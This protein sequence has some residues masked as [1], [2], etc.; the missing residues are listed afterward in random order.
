MAR[1]FETILYQ[2][3]EGPEGGYAVI[4]LNRPDKLNAFNEQLHADLRAALDLVEGDAGVRALVFTG[5]G[6]G[7]CAGQDLGDR[8]LKPG[9]PPRDTGAGLEAN[10]NPLVLRIRGLA[11]PVIA[12][13]NGVA[14]GAGCNFALAADIVLA[15]KS[16]RFI[17]AF[18]KIGLT[19]DC[20]GSFFLPRSLG[21]ARAMG[22]AMTG[23]PIDATQAAEWG[24]I[25]KCVEDDALLGE[26]H[27]LAAR[28]GAMSSV[29]L[30]LIKRSIN[31]S[32]NNDL[33]GQLA[34]EAN[35]QREAGKAPD[36]QEG[37][38]AFLEKRAPNYHP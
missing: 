1:E 35:L 24:L 25:W 27:A 15:A 26:T 8:I 9:D 16:A 10:Y 19:V 28:L 31:A 33:A 7:F 18:V 21:T 14:A 32:A 4:T 12:A 34:L 2:P 5:A 29:A 30:D 13:V 37:I 36:Y 22:F 3:N 23:D 17:Q 6:R 11:M 20:G 38:R